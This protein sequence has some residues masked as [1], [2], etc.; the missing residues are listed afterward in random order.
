LLPDCLAQ[1]LP[2]LPL[3]LLLLLVVLLLVLLL[4]EEATTLRCLLLRCLLLLQSAVH[5]YDSTSPAEQQQCSCGSGWTPAPG[6][7]STGQH[8]HGMAAHYRAW[9]SIVSD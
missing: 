4:E 3:Q 5:P 6:L 1:V 2:L 8:G 7:H 9:Q